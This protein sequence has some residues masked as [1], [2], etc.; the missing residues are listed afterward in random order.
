MV[1]FYGA[2]VYIKRKYF[3]FIQNKKLNEKVFILLNLKKIELLKTNIC[4][5]IPNHPEPTQ[6]N[7]ME[8]DFQDF[9]RKFETASTNVMNTMGGTEERYEAV[10]ESLSVLMCYRDLIEENE[11]YRIVK[12]IMVERAT[13]FK[14]QI[15]NYHIRKSTIDRLHAICDQL[16]SP[17]DYICG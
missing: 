14:R 9:H 10:I 8:Q 7:K 3:N 4:I 17:Y 11:R 2:I 13:F 1:L 6:P 5:L 15:R 12:D 16:L